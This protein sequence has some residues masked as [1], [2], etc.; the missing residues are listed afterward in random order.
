MKRCIEIFFV[1]VLLLMSFACSD[2]TNK[3]FGIWRLDSLSNCIPNLQ[4]IELKPDGEIIFYYPDDT[5]RW[6]T[7]VKVLS[8]FEVVFSGYDE[9]RNSL[10]FHA[11]YSDGK[12][13]LKNQAKK[14]VSYTLVSPPSLGI[15]NMEKLRDYPKFLNSLEREIMMTAGHETIKIDFQITKIYGLTDSRKWIAESFCGSSCNE[16]EYIFILTPSGLYDLNV[17]GNA[18]YYSANGKTHKKSFKITTGSRYWRIT[19]QI[20]EIMK[21]QMIHPKL[22]NQ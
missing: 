9:G 7:K 8:P 16:T 11:S 5:I 3:V 6:K 2:G 4:L 15:S 1:A 22:K 12:L 19:P 17:L 14:H 18:K 21:K 13:F 20:S 10:I